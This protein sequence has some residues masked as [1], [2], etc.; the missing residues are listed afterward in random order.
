MGVSEG[1]LLSLMLT[2]TTKKHLG[3]QRHRHVSAWLGLAIRRLGQHQK[4]WG[5]AWGA[6]SHLDSIGS[7]VNG[8]KLICQA[9]PFLI[10][11]VGS[12]LTESLKCLHAGGAFPDH[13]I[14]HAHI[15]VSTTSLCLSFNYVSFSV[16]ILYTSSICLLSASSTGTVSLVTMGI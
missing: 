9:G 7:S 3:D 13:R 6:A 8:S 16:I 14:Q 10:N 2:A 15:S 5:L 4:H 1:L 12:F 11:W